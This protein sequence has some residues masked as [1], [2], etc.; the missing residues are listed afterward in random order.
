MRSSTYR[1]AWMP[2]ATVKC[3]MVH[4]RHA[5]AVLLLLPVCAYPQAMPERQLP[6]DQSAFQAAMAEADP[7]KRLTALRAFSVEY[8]DS[9]YFDS[10]QEAALDLLLQAFPAKTADIRDQ[11]QVNVANA[12]KGYERLLEESR[13]ANRL[14]EAGVLLPLAQ[15]LAEDATRNMNEAVYLR[16][17]ARMYGGLQAEMPTPQE[18]HGGYTEARA[19]AVLSLAHVYVRQGKPALAGPLLK[20]AGTLQPRSVQL[21]VLRGQLASIDGDKISA[22]NELEQAAVLGEVPPAERDLLRRLYADSHSGAIDQAAGLEAE[23]DRRWAELNPPPF[24]PAPHPQ[25]PLGHTVLLELLTGAG[26]PPCVGADIAAESLLP[27]R[28]AQSGVPK[29][30]ETFVLLEWDEH[31]PRPDPLTNPDGVARAETLGAPNTPTFFLDGKRMEVFGGTRDDAAATYAGLQRLVDV[32]GARR[33]G[34]RL[35]LSTTRSPDGKVQATAQVATE[36]EESLAAITADENAAWPG[37]SITVAARARED[38]AQPP[39][40]LLNMAL[41]EDHVRYSGEN[42]MRFHRMVVRATSS[43]P[44]FG[45]PLHPGT[46]Q[47]FA[48]DFDIAGLRQRLTQYLQQFQAA[49]DRFGPIRF[50][51]TDVSLR[52]A[53]LGVVAFVQDARTHRVVQ[54]AYAPLDRGGL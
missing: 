28:S 50:L 2:C 44:A 18:L 20:E 8:Q 5:A 10:V 1:T 34:V 12:D 23:L 31:V 51:S 17:M 6:A 30:P 11:V 4:I 21:H 49:N 48:H 3:V 24:T 38:A 14:A 52:P 35:T 45:E 33:S 16:G 13:E 43:A 39:T 46:H 42:G 37:D 27:E 36:P 19:T 25:V 47:T 29:G 26:C 15:R 22:L 40:L 9:K 32:Q 41:V 53:E 54:S 7:T